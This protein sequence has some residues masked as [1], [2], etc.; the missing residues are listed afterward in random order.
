LTE[1]E[2]GL[3]LNPAAPVDEGG[4]A[5]VG[6]ERGVLGVGVPGCRSRQ[7][8]RRRPRGGFE[9]VV[10]AVDEERADEVVCGEI[11]RAEPD[12]KERDGDQQDACAQRQGLPL[13][14]R[15]L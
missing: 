14:S 11:G 4:I 10:D 5:A 6:E 7:L 12:D 1:G 2:P 3:A 13:G 8:C 9:L 15:R